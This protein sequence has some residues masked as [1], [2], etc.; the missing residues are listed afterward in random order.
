MLRRLQIENFGLIAHASVEFANGATIFTGETGSGK[1]MLIGALEFAL[2]ARAAGDVVARDA[3]K[4]TVTLSFEPDDELRSRLNADGFEIDPGEE[5]TIVRE[6]SDGGRTGVRVNGKPSTAAYVRAMSE[7]IAETI[8]Q[9]E[10]QRLLSPA[11]HLEQLDRFAGGEALRAR[12][13]VAGAHVRATALEETLGRLQRDDEGARRRY[14]DAA[15]AAG[16]IEAARLEAGEDE[17]LEARRRYLDNVERVA[18][19]LRSAREAL[20]G[21]DAGA[22]TALGS[23]SAAL[24]AVADV[25]PDLRALAQTTAALQSEATGVASELASALD[26]TELDPAELEALN[27]R[28][29]VIDR[30]KRKYGGSVAAVRAFANAARTAAA[31]YEGRDSRIAELAAEASNARRALQAA[32][33]RLT[34]LRK[35]AGTRLAKRVVEEFAEIALASGRFEVAFDTLDATGPN[36]AERVEFLFA[37][38]AGEPARPLSRVA[39]GGELSRVL[40]ALVVVLAGLRGDDSAL[41]FDEIDAGIGG[42]TA[43]AV[44]A[45]IGRQAREGQ[46]VC[47]T[48]HAQLATWADRHYV[49]DKTERKST[50]TISVRCISAAAQREEELA[51]MLSGETHEVAV[52]HARA[53]LSARP[54][55]S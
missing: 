54:V 36:G 28:L 41:V 38:N 52:K 33:T 51:R 35:K 26:A 14:E 17:R 4:A 55:R 30:L 43:A 25:S 20:A 2:G 7:A 12:E 31:E 5:A 8:G 37:A 34:A 18:Q 9:H 19:A 27:E 3:S 49:L 32:A 29:D 21:D 13:A 22:V 16:E 10:A 39:S 15:F 44:G 23:A 47:V 53:L 46:V 11:Y 48:H 6:M 50:T 24:G 40:L 45:R 42:A 1:T